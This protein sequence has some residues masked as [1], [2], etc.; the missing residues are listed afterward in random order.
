MKHLRKQ[1]V[2]VN[3][4][5]MIDKKKSGCVSICSFYIIMP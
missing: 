4:M 2:S 1:K 3:S 5:I